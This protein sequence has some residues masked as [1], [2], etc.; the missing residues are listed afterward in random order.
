MICISGYS[1]FTLWA[2]VI[3][4]IIGILIS[5]KS[6][7]GCNASIISIACRPS[8][9]S[10]TISNPKAL[11]SILFLINSLIN[12]SSSI[13]SILYIHSLTFLCMVWWENNSNLRAA[14]IC[15]IN[16]EPIFSSEMQ[17]NSVIYT[18]YTKSSP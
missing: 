9:A 4:L 3:P 1:L 11:K 15:T 10:P 18:A 13:I 17:L 6:K 2:N 7:F 16:I 8:L 5:N 12:I 14:S